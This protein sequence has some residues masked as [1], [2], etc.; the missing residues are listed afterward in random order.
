L[1]SK[2]HKAL[3]QDIADITDRIATVLDTDDIQSLMDLTTEHKSAMSQLRQVGFSRE[4][5]LLG[6]VEIIHD[7][8]QAVT[9]QITG[10]RDD[11]LHQLVMFEQKKKATAAYTG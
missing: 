6:Q 3:Y 11:L 8:I 1:P 4:T 10:Q 7:Q 5:E 2:P 9:E